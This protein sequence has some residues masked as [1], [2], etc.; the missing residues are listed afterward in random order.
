M[1]Q[2][3]IYAIY[4]PN[5]QEV[6]IGYAGNPISRLSQLQTGTTDRLDLLMTFVGGLAEE[7]QIHKELA[8]YR[9]SGE[10]FKYSPLVFSILSDFMAAQFNSNGC[11]TIDLKSLVGDLEEENR[12]LLNVAESSIEIIQTVQKSLVEQKQAWRKVAGTFLNISDDL[13]DAEFMQ[14]L[15][16]AIQKLSET[17]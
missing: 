6:K 17:N 10:W 14:E 7:K 5:K 1:S 13:D 8:N 4:C 9:I 12:K 2:T 11:N 3:F 15:R 16:N